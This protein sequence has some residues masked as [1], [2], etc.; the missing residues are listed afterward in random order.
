MNFKVTTWGAK[1]IDF[2]M[3]CMPLFL[4]GKVVCHTSYVVFVKIV[5]AH[6]QSCNPL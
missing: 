3:R 2:S 5:R 6:T 4:R 1:N